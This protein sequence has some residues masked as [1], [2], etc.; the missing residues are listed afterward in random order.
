LPLSSSFKDIQG[1]IRTSE[2]IIL[3]VMKIAI[4]IAVFEEVIKPGEIFILNE[5]CDGEGEDRRPIEELYWIRSAEE[6]IGA[7]E[8]EIGIY[9]AEYYEFRRL[10]GIRKVGEGCYELALVCY[11]RQEEKDQSY[12]LFLHRINS[13][14]E[15]L[16]KAKELFDV[17]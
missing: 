16:A 4:D 9:L 17:E 10:N 8:M 2:H 14:G 12:P 13:F 11:D 1:K 6:I 5:A 3:I 7:I 15:M